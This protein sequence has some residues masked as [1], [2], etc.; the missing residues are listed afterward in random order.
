MIMPYLVY[1][2]N[3]E[4]ALRFYAS[5]FDGKVEALSR[6]TAETGG[7]ALDGKV[8]HAYVS[9]GARGGISAA[10]QAEPV[11]HD[12]A[13][14]LLVHCTSLSEAQRA[15]DA[16]AEGGEVLCRLTPHPPPDDGGS[17]GLVRDRYGYVWILTALNDTP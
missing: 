12:D 11:K 14:Q 4:E 17:G 3:C 2:G 15:M 16:L 7:P 6:Y 5:I 1:Q 13:M 9:F 8:M 10:D